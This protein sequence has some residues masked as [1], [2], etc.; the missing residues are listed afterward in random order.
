MKEKEIREKIE[1]LNLK[2]ANTDGWSL[3]DVLLLD[4]YEKELREDFGW[5]KE[6]TEALAPNYYHH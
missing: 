3:G 4:K 5:T 1:K 2:N 6:Q